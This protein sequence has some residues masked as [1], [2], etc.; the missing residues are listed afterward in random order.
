MFKVNFL[1]FQK[2]N[3]AIPH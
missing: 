1:L 2:A 3:K